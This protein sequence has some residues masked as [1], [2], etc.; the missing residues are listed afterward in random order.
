MQQED[1]AQAKQEN[2]DEFQNKAADYMQI[3]M[4]QRLL[5]FWRR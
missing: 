3:M 4:K 1:K 5:T 2:L